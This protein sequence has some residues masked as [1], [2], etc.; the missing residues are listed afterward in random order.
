MINYK[1]LDKACKTLGV[2]SSIRGNNPTN[3]I[4]MDVFKEPFDFGK[5]K[6]PKKEMTQVLMIGQT[7]S[8]LKSQFPLNNHFDNTEESKKELLKKQ[9]IDKILPVLNLSMDFWLKLGLFKCKSDKRLII[10][11]GEV[12]EIDPEQERR[13]VKMNESPFR[14][15]HNLGQ[16]PK[17]L[18]ID[19]R[20]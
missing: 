17:G 14:T 12:Y 3:A 6:F 19:L 9:A 11:S 2:D 4:P 7:I 16:N 13:W 18:D 5:I 10:S 20:G 1:S 15:N 8:N